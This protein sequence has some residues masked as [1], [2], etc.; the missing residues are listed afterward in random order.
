MSALKSF[1]LREFGEEAETRTG[2]S[3]GAPSSLIL[4][5]RYHEPKMA[6]QFPN[7]EMDDEEEDDED[8]YYKHLMEKVV[9]ASHEKNES[10]KV[11]S[12]SIIILSMITFH[13]LS[14]FFQYIYFSYCLLHI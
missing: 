8:A 10:A 12:M 5:P 1:K 4:A 2:R 11:A 7:F 13:Y 9:L 6:S 3:T 14:F